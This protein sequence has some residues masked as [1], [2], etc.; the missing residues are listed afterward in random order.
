MSFD[1]PIYLRLPFYPILRWLYWAKP[2]T[3]I[4]VENRL[5]FCRYKEHVSDWHLRSLTRIPVD[6]VHIE[7]RDP[8]RCNSDRYHR[9][10]AGWYPLEEQHREWLHRQ[11]HSLPS[12]EDI[13]AQDTCLDW[14]PSVQLVVSVWQIPVEW[15]SLSEHTANRVPYWYRYCVLIDTDSV[16]CKVSRRRNSLQSM[17]GIPTGYSNPR[18]VYQ[19]HR[20]TQNHSVQ[21]QH[22]PLRIPTWI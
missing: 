21:P 17:L 2:D 12:N 6:L 9:T 22:Q 1:Q 18:H 5:P 7:W 10:P 19:S 8:E 20:L 16:Q 4:P 11:V 3:T 13:A 15:Q 14:M